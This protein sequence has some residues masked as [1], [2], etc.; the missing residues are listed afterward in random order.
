[1]ACLAVT[2]AR[3]IYGMEFSIVTWFRIDEILAGGTVALFLQ[4]SRFAS[5]SQKWPA[6]IPFLLIP[7]LFCSCHESLVYI[8][9]LR[10]YITA[11]LVY[12]T[13]HR[14]SD[15]LQR[16][17]SSKLL[18]Y[19]A[20]TSYALYVIHPLTYAGWLGEGDVVVK[21]A[22]RILSFILTFLFAHLSS[23]YFEKR[24][25]TLG[26]TLASRIERNGAESPNLR[27]Q[28]VVNP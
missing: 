26:H 19:F 4:L 9:Y 5:T 18:A 24:W 23:E 15:F 16:L 6:A 12:S 25:N 27:S 21:Y 10:P 3:V 20:K 7:P 13:I 17:L 22:K 28:P 8:D 2:A 14:K 11:L 1:M